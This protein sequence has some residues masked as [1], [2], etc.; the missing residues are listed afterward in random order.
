M[1]CRCAAQ[2]HDKGS[3]A[4]SRPAMLRSRWRLTGASSDLSEP[5]ETYH[6]R[7]TPP[8][9]RPGVLKGQ[10]YSATATKPRPIAPASVGAIHNDHEP[11]LHA[12]SIA[13]NGTHRPYYDLM[14]WACLATGA[15][16]PAAVVPVML[17]PDNLPRRFQIIAANLEDR[18]RPLPARGCSKRSACALRHL[19]LPHS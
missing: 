1:A 5:A 7:K 3:N 14:L 8:R 6:P 18:T 13:V 11:D 16:L 15:G 12:R 2:R 9:Q 19:Q 17:G 4:I 10:R